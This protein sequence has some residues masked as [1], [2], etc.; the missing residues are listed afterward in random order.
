MVTWLVL[1]S[2][3]EPELWGVRS[4][5]RGSLGAGEGESVLIVGAVF[6]DELELL[7]KPGIAGEREGSLEGV[8]TLGAEP[9]DA[10]I[11][12]IAGLGA[13]AGVGREVRGAETVRG[14]D[15]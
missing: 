10:G 5:R 6:R 8:R 11:E 12:A 9:C 4:E 14:S 2:D 3:P 7:R 15:A 1:P 13:G